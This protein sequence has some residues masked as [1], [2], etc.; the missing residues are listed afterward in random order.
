MI[1]VF[2]S[3]I[4][5]TIKNINDYLLHYLLQLKTIIKVEKYIKLIQPG[6]IHWDIFW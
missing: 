1:L 3:D 5:S 4:N 6:Q 2:L